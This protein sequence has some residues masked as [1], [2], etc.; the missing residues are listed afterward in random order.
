MSMTVLRPA[1]RLL[2]LYFAYTVAISVALGGFAW[3][4]VAVAAAAGVAIWVLTAMS[5]RSVV[6]DK[7]RDWAPVALVPVAYWQMDFIRRPDAAA[8]FARQWL[9]VD[10]WLF[11]HAHPDAWGGVG[12]GLLETAYALTYAIP[13][14][15]VAILYVLHRRDRVDRFHRI[16]FAGTL[17]A[18]AL[19]PFFPS[20]SP[21][22]VELAGWQPPMNVV[23][24]F[25][26]WLLDR[27]DIHSSVF[28]SGHVAAA[29]SAAFGM[30]AA[31]PERK[32]VGGGMLVLALLIAAAT[33]YGRYHYA[34][35]AI[36]SIAITVIA[37]RFSV[38][39]RTLVVA[40]V[41]A[42]S[43]APSR[44]AAEG[45]RP[46]Q[47]QE[48]IARAFAPVLVFHTDEHFFPVNSRDG[49]SGTGDLQRVGDRVAQYAAMS[50][51]SR[52]ARASVGYRVFSRV[53]RGVES[54][55]VEYWC[56]YLYNAYTVRVG[57]LPIRVRDNHP[58]DL[59]RLYLVLTPTAADA[60]GPDD[61]MQH[62]E[63]W[64]TRAFRVRL[65]VA[66]AH[67]GS[68]PPNQYNAEIGA[69]VTPPLTILVERGSHAM[70]PDVNRDGRFTPSIDST[71]PGKLLWGIRDGGNA[72]GWY[73]ASYMDMRDHTAIRLCADTAAAA[74]PGCAPYALYPVTDLQRW[75]DSLNLSTRERLDVVG[76]TSWVT[77][78]FGDVRVE[79]LMV[80]ADPADGRML[81]RMLTRRTRTQEGYAVGFTTIGRTPAPIVGKRFFWDV[82][83]QRM[84]DIVA[85]VSL[86]VPPGKPTRL[87]A[88][89]TGSYALDAT[90]NV[91]VGAGWFSAGQSH[92]NPVVGFDVRVGRFHVQP[93][94][95][96]GHDWVHAN[97]VALF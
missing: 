76:H 80:P 39:P 16:F 55:V 49:V 82:P 59:E 95:R 96:L 81:D 26:I 56:H 17:V 57:W 50:K 84:P 10:T 61:A 34:V 58:E 69:P 23:R 5:P 19:L 40:V 46:P 8:A 87:Q 28:P 70:A 41:A 62:D 27:A 89:L 78:I 21:R 93:L 43:L 86:I 4:V 48:A 72:W 13:P 30:F 66:N 85:D 52:L 73:R 64:A 92:A 68:V 11:R 24:H 29:F 33:V 74:E 15:A 67:D 14:G 79:N 47:E 60:G 77:R 51:E 38:R 20:A 91:L 53:D 90:T 94:Y 88:F 63:T 75:F 12:S 42:I 71:A 44:A 37:W 25:N 36:G 1:E 45:T 32:R 65:V 35:D 9:P 6:A 22:L 83:S 31:L 7:A 3:R 97:L 54:V 2:L 18:Y